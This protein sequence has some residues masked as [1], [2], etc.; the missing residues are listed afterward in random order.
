MHFKKYI[1]FAVPEDQEVDTKF[2]SRN[3]FSSPQE[4]TDYNEGI[5]SQTPFG[6]PSSKQKN[7]SQ[8]LLLEPQNLNKIFENKQ[9]VENSETLFVST[10]YFNKI[11]RA[12][13]AKQN[14]NSLDDQNVKE[15]EKTVDDV[16]ELLNKESKKSNNEEVVIELLNDLYECMEKENLMNVKMASK[17]KIYILKCL[18]KFVESSNERLLLNIGRIILAVCRF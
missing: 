16:I 8:C 10:G 6:R 12:D 2:E 5:R 14:N 18:Y 1:Y 9:I 11:I 3:A 7:L 15:R 13:N 17:M 4:R